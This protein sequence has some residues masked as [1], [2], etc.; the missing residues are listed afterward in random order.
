ML[1]V[2]AKEGDLVTITI[3]KEN[4]EWGYNPCPAGETLAKVLGYSE[5]HHG[6]I[7]G[8]RGKPG[9]YINKFWLRLLLPPPDSREI[10][11]ASCRLELVDEEEYARRLA[12]YMRTLEN[13]N[14]CQEEPLRDLPE[15]PFWEMD[16]VW[17]KEGPMPPKVY[18]QLM[19]VVG[20]DYHCLN[21]K[22]NDG[23][24]FPAYRI[25]SGMG[26][27]WTT[28]ANED[29]MSLAERGP[30]WRYAH[31]EPV[32][33]PSLEEEAQFF[34][35]IGETE[36][37]RNPQDNLYHWTKEEVLEAIR[38]GIAHGFTV[39]KG[40]FGV[41]LYISAKRFDNAELGARVAAATLAGFGQ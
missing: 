38:G 26:A 6:R 14:Q 16:W 37:V 30:V 3:P 24:K 28:S 5:I 15:T 41:G 9:V 12:A 18:P 35:L 2:L 36:E 39:A 40:F 33:F 20:I 34:S 27:G 11:E 29:G 25:S 17:A 21:A 8:R 13:P 7:E 32:S 4:R 1:G 23:S 31:G 19:Q 10:T 22:R